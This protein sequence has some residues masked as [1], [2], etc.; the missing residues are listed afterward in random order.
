M[1][2]AANQLL[3]TLAL[4]VGTTVLIKMGKAAYLWVTAVPMVFVA[5]ITLSGSYELCVLF[6]QKGNKVLDPGQAFALYLD[7]ALVGVVALLALIVLSDSARQWYGYLV[8]GWPFTSSEVLAASEAAPTSATHGGM[9][10]PP[11]RCC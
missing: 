11:G 1:F 8:Q 3:G 5:V 6:L 9:K 2:G 4:C 7:G 10:L